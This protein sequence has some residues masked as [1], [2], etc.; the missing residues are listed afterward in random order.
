[1]WPLSQV[2]ETEKEKRESEIEHRRI[3][4]KCTQVLEEY[5]TV[6]RKLRPQIIKSRPYYEE[7]WKS[8]QRLAVS[9]VYWWY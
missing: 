3:L 4:D 8:S 2:V 7:R 9:G 1:M 5:R 6:E